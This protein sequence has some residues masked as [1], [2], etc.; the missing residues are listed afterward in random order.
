MLPQ[1][2]TLHSTKD[3][4]WHSCLPLLSPLCP[5]WFISTALHRLIGIL[6]TMF[7]QAQPFQVLLNADVF[8]SEYQKS[9]NWPMSQTS[10]DILSLLTL[11]VWH[12]HT[13]V[14]WNSSSKGLK[15]PLS[16]LHSLSSPLSLFFLSVRY[17]KLLPSPLKCP[18]H[19]FHES[20]PG[21]KNLSHRLFLHDL[22]ATN[23]L[24]RGTFAID[25]MRR[26]TL[27][28]KQAKCYF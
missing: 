4:T 15:W 10:G 1:S 14:Y 9:F 24:K 7:T 12:P 11:S 18:Q 19:A 20:V 26:L 5:C 27:S 23:G 8:S 6:S 16:Q 21:L 28:L 13:P 17:L 3:F 22:W 2:L 25:L